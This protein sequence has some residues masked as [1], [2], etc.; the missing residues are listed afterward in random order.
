MARVGYF[1]L[2]F[3]EKLWIVIF[4]KF[5]DYQKFDALF[6]YK[7]I[8][9]EYNFNFLFNFHLSTLKQIAVLL[10]LITKLGIQKF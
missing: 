4:G 6:I 2:F 8:L 5:Y 10:K 9:D 1:L 3:L 7:E